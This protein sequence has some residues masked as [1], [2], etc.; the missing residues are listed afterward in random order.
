[1]KLKFILYLLCVSVARINIKHFNVVLPKMAPT[2]PHWQLGIG[3]SESIES[4]IR[5]RGKLKIQKYPMDAIN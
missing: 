1:M 4:G 5:N 3:N 2:H